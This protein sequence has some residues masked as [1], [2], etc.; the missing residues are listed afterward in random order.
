MGGYGFNNVT[1]QLLIGIRGKVK[2]FGLQEKT[3]VK[4]KYVPRS[5]SKKPEAM[6]QLIEKCVV[7]T[8]WKHRGLEMNCRTPR[9]NWYPHGDEITLEDIKNWQK[10]K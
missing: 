10:L 6:W 4:S 5:H 3:I 7:K 1:E 9:K 2:P 8:R